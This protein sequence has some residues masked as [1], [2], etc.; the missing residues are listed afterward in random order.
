[1]SSSFH[2]FIYFI[3][4]LSALLTSCKDEIADNENTR[5]TSFKIEASVNSDL[6]SKDIIGKIDGQNIILEVP[7]NLDLSKIRASFT[8]EGKDVLIGNTQQISGR[9]VNNFTNPITYTIV[10]QNNFRKDYKVTIL[11]T[12]VSENSLISFSF[13]KKNNSLLLRDFN[14]TVNGDIIEITLP[15]TT[16]NLVATFETN[17][18]EITI[19]GVPQSSGVTINDFSQAVVY[20]LISKDGIKKTYSIRIN[21]ISAIP[22]I[23]IT[24]DDNTPI[25]S[26]DVYVYANINIIANGWSEDYS[27]RTRI[28]GRG[29]S[30]WG[31][32]KKPY[33][34]KLDNDVAILNLAA[35]KD[36]VLLANYLDP[37][38]MLN[39]VAF[40]IGQL[41]ELQYTNHAIPVDVTLNNTYLGNYILTEQVEISKSRVNIDKKNGVL[42]EL[43]TNYDE[44]FKFKSANYQLPVMVKEPDIKSD[45]QFQIIKDD[46]HQF[47]NAVASNLFPNTNYKNF[48]DIESLVKYLIVYNLTHNMEINHPK[49]TYLYK[50]AGSKY[51]MGPIWDFDWAFDFE[52]KNV[53]F[54][55]FTTP[56]FG[57]LGTASTGYTFFSRFLED[58]EITQLYKEIWSDFHSNKLSQLLSYIDFYAASITESQ[59]KDVELWPNYSTTNFPYKVKILKNWLQNRAKY[60]DSYVK[61]F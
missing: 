8:F 13:L 36:W 55:S 43:D 2:K 1:M 9:T 28:R 40:K 58:P 30:T 10:T 14:A 26:K 49:S 6:L 7:D 41:L 45:A 11:K 59:K 27:G 25:T 44:D 29:N 3:I 46:F 24:T 12:G 53:H 42:L 18:G 60:I 50:D 20:T 57:K 47:E 48:I 61:D 22:H 35:E 56:L 52:G 32:P 39:A 37:T 5:F 31:L 4:F 19:N 17:A 34:L 33:R 21:W 15:S 38:L 51:F 23:N 16:K 54:E